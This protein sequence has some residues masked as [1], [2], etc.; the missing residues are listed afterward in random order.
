MVYSQSWSPCSWSQ[1][2]LR[3]FCS[4]ADDGQ[5]EGDTDQPPPISTCHSLGYHPFFYHVQ[6]GLNA[7]GLVPFLMMQPVAYHSPDAQKQVNTFKNGQNQM[8]QE[9][10]KN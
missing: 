1:L 7:A 5:D 6:A 10:S 3:P 4:S 8:L 9:A 2:S